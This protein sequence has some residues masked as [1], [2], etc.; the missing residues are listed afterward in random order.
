MQK[1]PKEQV[2]KGVRTLGSDKERSWEV[3]MAGILPNFFSARD[4]NRSA[5]IPKPTRGKGG[6]EYAMLGILFANFRSC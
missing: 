6:T 5:E 2:W 4:A 1:G 3:K